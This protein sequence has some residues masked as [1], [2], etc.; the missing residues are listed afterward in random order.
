MARLPRLA[1]DGE[2][3]LV[4]HCGHNGQ[5]VFRDDQDCRLFLAALR[6]AHVRERVAVHGY[7]LLPQRLWLLATPVESA[8]LSRLMQAAG[9]R[10][11]SAF[12]R[13]YARS[14]TVWDGRYRSTVVASGPAV[15][16]VLVF[17]EQSPVREGL[18]AQ[19][20]DFAWSSARHHVAQSVD[21]LITDSAA[22]WSLGN[23]PFDRAAAYGGLLAEPVS[24]DRVREISNSAQRGWAL[25]SEADLTLLQER[26]S[27]PL[28]ARRRGR[29][30]LSG[31]QSK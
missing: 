9:R 23:T 18:V 22:Y 1:I 27:R 11:T 4:L 12:N 14:G 28:V 31:A 3:H 10:Y 2:V 16:D 21:G 29:P 7:A 20:V 8:G 17:I 15:V 26:T 30:P 24:L 19:A 25:A 6:D 13:R 5:S